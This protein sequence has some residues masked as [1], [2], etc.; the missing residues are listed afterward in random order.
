MPPLFLLVS[1]WGR[2][3]FC[4]RGD[5]IAETDRGRG[6]EY[7]RGRGQGRTRQDQQAGGKQKEID[8]ER[9]GR[10]RQGREMD[11]WRREKG[12]S[13]SMQGIGTEG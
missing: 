7:G 8:G 11:S 12:E 10:E 4:L 3:Q 1:L 9:G 2:A 5:P 6:K 13:R